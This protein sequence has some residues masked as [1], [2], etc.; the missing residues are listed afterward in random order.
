MR[1][2]PEHVTFLRIDPMGL[3]VAAAVFFGI[4]IGSHHHRWSALVVCIVLL[5][6]SMLWD[7]ARALP[8]DEHRRRK[9]RR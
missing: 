4:W 2:P 6:V 8:G 1:R 9:W 3:A 5:V 7:R